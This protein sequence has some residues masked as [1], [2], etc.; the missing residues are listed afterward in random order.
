MASCETLS[1]DLGE[2]SNEKQQGLWAISLVLPLGSTA[3]I[4]P[5]RE[6]LSGL[7]ELT[8]SQVIAFTMHCY[9]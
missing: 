9:E 1:W 7:M 6:A 8:A 4:G 5:L 3:Q 2:G